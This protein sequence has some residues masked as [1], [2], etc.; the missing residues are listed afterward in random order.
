LWSQPTGFVPVTVPNT[1]SPQIS[2]MSRDGLVVGG[3]VVDQS[4]HFYHS[5]VWD[6]GHGGR[7]IPEGA[8]HATWLHA[9]S[10]DGLQAVGSGSSSQG[11]WPAVWGSV[12]VWCDNLGPMTGVDSGIAYAMTPDGT[13]VVGSMT[14]PNGSASAFVWSRDAGMTILDTPSGLRTADLRCVSDDGA[15]AGGTSYAVDGGQVAVIWRRG[16]GVMRATD[17]LR[18]YGFNPPDLERI[19]GV[20]AN[21]RVICDRAYLFDLGRCGS[22]DFNHDGDPGTDADVEAFFHCLA[23][24]CCAQCDPSDFDGD[25][26]SGTDQD[27]E[28]FMRVLA[29]GNC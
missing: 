17:Y 22:T 7:C 3:I 19:V 11:T 24:D 29:G 18:L 15:L 23:G 12:Y 4:N 5:F 27:I 26:D 9:L 1:V 6:A 28:A 2:C 14:Y 25:G 8:N 16:L 13:T 10:H 20:S 21:S